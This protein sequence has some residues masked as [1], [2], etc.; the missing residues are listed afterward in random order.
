MGEFGRTPTINAA[1][2]RDHFPNAWTAVLA[3]GGIKG[4]QAYGRTTSADG[5]A[6]EEGQV[7][8]P[9]VLA[10]LCKALGVDPETYNMSEVGRPIKIAEGQPIEAVLA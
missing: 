3:G 9:D 8:V 7:D 6:V 5:E 10:T 4:G 1:G 2:G